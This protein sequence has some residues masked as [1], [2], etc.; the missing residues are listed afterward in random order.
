MARYKDIMVKLLASFITFKIT[1]V[2][3][4][5]NRESDM[6]SKINQSTPS[7]ISQ[8]GN[9]LGAIINAIQINVIENQDCEWMTN[10]I[11]FL[12]TKRVSEDEGRARKFRLRE[13]RFKIKSEKLY[14]Q[15]YGGPLLKCVNSWEVEEIMTEVHNGTCSTHQGANTLYQKKL[16]HGYYWLSMR[17]DCEMKVPACTT[18]QVFCK[19]VLGSQPPTTS[20]STT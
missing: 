6:L 17:M 7:Y 5:K 11:N 13:M 20:R 8:L 16:F 12:N 9:G 2:P 14:K 4:D 3:Q 19:N 15:S 10:L 1:Q 18:C